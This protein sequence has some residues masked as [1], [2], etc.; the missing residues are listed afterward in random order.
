MVAVG[1]AVVPEKKIPL[2]RAQRACCVEWSRRG[3]S[4]PAEPIRDGADLVVGGGGTA[5]T[6]L[7]KEGLHLSRKKMQAAFCEV[8]CSSS[9][10]AC[11]WWSPVGSENQCRNR[12]ADAGAVRSLARAK[13]ARGWDH[14][15]RLASISTGC[16]QG[17]ETR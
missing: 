3:S 5:L 13:R 10:M 14:S 8:T 4:S 2:M 15:V 6:G 16:S 12:D 17:L 1:C 9:T 11:S 7:A